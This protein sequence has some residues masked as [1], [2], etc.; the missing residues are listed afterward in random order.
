MHVARV[1]GFNGAVDLN[2]RKLLRALV[3]QDP[4]FERLQWGRG[5]ESTET[6]QH[7]VTK[8]IDLRQRFNG[9]V[10]LNPRK[11]SSRKPSCSAGTLLQW[12]RGFESTETLAQPG[13]RQAAFRCFNG[14]VDLN[15]RKHGRPA[16]STVNW[17][18]RFNG[19]VDLNPRK[20]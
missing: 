13:S 17:P 1:A 4:L 14:A 8:G 10:D 20:P 3:G 15:P 18:E 12:G 16:T 7:D 11:Q 2:P 9:A 19:A 5:F 6:E